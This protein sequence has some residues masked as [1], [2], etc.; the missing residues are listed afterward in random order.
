[1]AVRSGPE[2]AVRRRYPHSSHKEE[3]EQRVRHRVSRILREVKTECG[4]SN[5]SSDEDGESFQIHS[6]PC[7]CYVRLQVGFCDRKFAIKIVFDCLRA[8]SCQSQNIIEQQCG[9]IPVWVQ[10]TIPIKQVPHLFL[11]VLSVGLESGVASDQLE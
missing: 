9:K 3:R 11:P 1:M 7:L 2:L 4:D 10:V 8:V 5:V 6:M